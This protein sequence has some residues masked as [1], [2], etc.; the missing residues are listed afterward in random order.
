[1]TTQAPMSAEG[2]KVDETAEMFM[3]VGKIL[4]MQKNKMDLRFHLRLLLKE[5]SHNLECAKNDVRSFGMYE[6]CGPSYEQSY[7]EAVGREQGVR[8]IENQIVRMEKYQ[9]MCIHR[10]NEKYSLDAMYFL[11]KELQKVSDETQKYLAKKSPEGIQAEKN[12]AA[13]I[14]VKEAQRNRTNSVSKNDQFVHD[15]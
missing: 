13:K 2:I 14:A 10:F 11:Q 8:L 12:R 4:A 1:M 5:T 7:H 9:K 3:E 6:D 15:K